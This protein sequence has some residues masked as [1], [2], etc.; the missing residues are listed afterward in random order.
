MLWNAVNGR[1]PLGSTEMSYVSFGNGEKTLAVL[2][3]LSDG[4][5][6][7]K[8]K[9]LLLA[10]PYSRFLDR[11]TVYLFSR[12]NELPDGYSIQDMADD[13]ANVL[14]SLGLREVSVMG[15]SEGGM[16]AQ[17]LAIRHPELVG[18]LVIAVSAPRVNGLIRENVGRWIVLAEQGDHKQLMIDTAERSYSSG[19]LKKYRRIYPIIGAIG[20]PPDY[21]RFLINAGAILTFDVLSE[22]EKIS[23]PTLIIGAADDRVVGIDASF[24]MKERIRNSEIYIYRDLGHAAYEEAGDFYERVFRFLDTK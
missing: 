19:Y 13:Q 5:V 2:P 22:M 8:G 23:C 6:T 9:A 4:L 16:I 21:R 10:K 14:R 20:K 7:V 1:I 17:T 18:K 12:K 15:V 3:G 24:E 11:Y